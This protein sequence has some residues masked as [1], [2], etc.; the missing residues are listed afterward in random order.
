[1]AVGKFNKRKESSL[2]GHTVVLYE[3]AGGKDVSTSDPFIIEASQF[4]VSM[5]GESPLL[6]NRSD[7]EEYARIVSDAWLD[8][9]AL[10]PKIVG[11]HG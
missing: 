7:L 5:S 11:I 6:E 4:G 10:R 2:L 9:L 3:H 8:H 1:M